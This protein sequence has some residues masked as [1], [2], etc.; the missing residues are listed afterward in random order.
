MKI[1]V[2]SAVGG[3]DKTASTID[4]TSNLKVSDDI[5]NKIKNDVGDY[6]I[7]SILTAAAK[8]KS[9]VE[10]ESFPG[11]SPAYKKHKIEE[12]L[13]GKANLSFEGDLLD[14]L[15]YR[16]TKD[17]IEIGWFGDQAAKADGHANISGESR[18]PKRRLIPD[19]KQEFKPSIQKEIESIIAD[20]IGDSVELDK[21]DFEDVDTKSELYT[22]L[23]DYFPGLSKNE[24]R[25]AITR[26][27]ALIKFFE[28]N[29]LFDLL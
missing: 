25:G 3:E 29:D 9:P 14:A 8:A 11:L 26:T 21:G 24:I 28:D 12:G 17:G 15:E 6:L 5:K 18:I 7:E 4:L 10:D 20:A 2:T 23:E 13:G 19:E 16:T 22:A 27:P 1:K